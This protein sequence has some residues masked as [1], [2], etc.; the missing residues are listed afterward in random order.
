VSIGAAGGREVS[1]ATLLRRAGVADADRAERLI[2]E[3]TSIT[4]AT[5]DDVPGA[6]SY[7]SDP[8]AALLCLVRLAESARDSG[9]LDTLTALAG[10][11][12]G[13]KLAVLVGAS[14]ALG[15]FLVRHPELIEDFAQWEVRDPFTETDARAELLRAVGADPGETNPVASLAGSE[16]IDAMR[17]AYRRVLTRIAATD[18]F[19]Q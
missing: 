15:D 9:H 14:T 5:L 16:G 12:G 1:Q 3:L 8:D 13:A 10:T 6:L 17:V 7:L 4:G 19:A 18:L 2:A 11:R